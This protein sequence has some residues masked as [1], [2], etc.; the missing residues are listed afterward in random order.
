LYGIDAGQLV[1]DLAA[2]G[3]VPMTL[4]INSPGGDAFAGLALY[5]ALRQ[6]TGR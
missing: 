5:E 1:R 3:P 4:R 2:A 6:H